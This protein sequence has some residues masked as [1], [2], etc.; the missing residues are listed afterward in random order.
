MQKATT[1]FTLIFL[2]VFTAWGQLEIRTGLDLTDDHFPQEAS[3]KGELKGPF[4]FHSQILEGTVRRY[5]LFIPAQYEAS[6]PAS[7]LVFQDGQRATNPKG[8][9]RAIR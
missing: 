6:Q 1:I 8:P 2:S 5:W 3:P 4:E 9:I 7:V